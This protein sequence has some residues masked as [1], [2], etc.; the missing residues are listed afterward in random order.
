M[1]SILKILILSL[2]LNYVKAQ[3]NLVLNGSFEQTIICPTNMYHINNGLLENVSNPGSYSPDYYNICYNILPSGGFGIPSNARG[4]QFARTGIAYCGIAVWEKNSTQ[5]EYIQLKLAE[6][7]KTGHN[8]VFECYLNRAE[9]FSHAVSNFGAY[10][11]L[12]SVSMP[13]IDIL[14]FVPQ[15]NNPTGNY[16]A[17]TLNWLPF[18][19]TFLAQ[20]GEQYVILGNFNAMPENVDTLLQYYGNGVYPNGTYYYIDDVSLIDLDSTLAV[21]ENEAMAKVE[22]FPNPATR[23]LNIKCNKPYQQYSIT[24][25]KGNT[26]MQNSISKP[27]QLQIDINALPSGFYVISFIN[28]QGYIIR[29]K[30]VKM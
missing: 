5:R 21:N 22:V 17:D 26:L 28:K 24:D 30:F 25:I 2:S 11:S 7:L 18:T 27:E 20:G 16:F 10:F 14:P 1:N 12:D 19:G 3:T 13:A 4:Y 29:E 15:I 9:K 8:Y 6:P 23:V